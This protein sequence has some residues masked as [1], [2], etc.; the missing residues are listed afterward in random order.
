MPKIWFK[1][2]VLVSLAVLTLAGAFLF[3]TSVRAA[4]FTV[5][6]V[7]DS[8]AGSLRQAM[9]DAN[10]TAGIDTINFNIGSGHKQIIP[11]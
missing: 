3:A 2:Q 7:A 10:A 9:I 4:T 11:T 1:L 8:G 5:T 6:N